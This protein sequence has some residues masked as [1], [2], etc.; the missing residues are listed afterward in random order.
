MDAEPPEHVV[1][2]LVASEAAQLGFIDVIQSDGLERGQHPAAQLALVLAQRIAVVQLDQQLFA[3]RL[4]GR[5]A[6]SA[7]GV[8]VVEDVDRGPIGHARDDELGQAG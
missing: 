7:E 4:D 2:L 6:N 3:T 5:D 8:V 1:V